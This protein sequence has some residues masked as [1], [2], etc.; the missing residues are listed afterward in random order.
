MAKAGPAATFHVDIV[1]DVMCPW[2]YIGKR[3]FERMVAQ[4]GDYSFQV[5]W[6]PFQ[7]DPTLPP[8]GLA[9]TDYLTRKFGGPEAVEAVYGPIRA[10]GAAEGLAFEFDRIA[11]SPNTVN[12][13]RLIAWA[14][15]Q[16]TADRMVE[17]LFAAYFIDGRDIGVVEVLA[18]IAATC[19]MD[20]EIILARL[21]SDEDLQ[22]T[23]D[24]ANQTRQMGVTGVPTF[25]IDKRY[26][27]E[28]AQSP[29][30]LGQAFRQIAGSYSAA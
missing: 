9:R 8:H 7:L 12:A 13:H 11:V 23:Q 18:E 2:C 21:I 22:K 29:E 24:A 14:H 27:V 28:G 1:S 15:Q 25:I 6:R 5:T 17:A 4:H 10:A 30:H 26:V 3:R 20:G 16:G 19:A